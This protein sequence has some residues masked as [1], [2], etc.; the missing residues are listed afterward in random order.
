M[1]ESELN[2]LEKLNM[3][4][5]I[6]TA[7]NSPNGKAT[8]KINRVTAP[9]GN[10]YEF[11]EQITLEVDFVDGLYEL[12]WRNNEHCLNIHVVAKTAQELGKSFVI[13]VDYLIS[14]IFQLPDSDLSP[15][16]IKAKNYINDLL[17]K[18]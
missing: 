17:I 3:R 4:N 18:Q 15:C 5:A 1:T 7:L 6:D 9:N 14:Y 8:T 11:R 10:V 13:E 16:L 2:K 12:F